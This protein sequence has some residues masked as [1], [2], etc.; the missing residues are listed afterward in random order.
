MPSCLDTKSSSSHIN[1]LGKR[2]PCS[3]KL[4]MWCQYWQQLA[5]TSWQCSSPKLHANW[6]LNS[7]AQGHKDLLLELDLFEVC[8]ATIYE[9]HSSENSNCLIHSQIHQTPDLHTDCELFLF[10]SYLFYLRPYFAP[11]RT[12]MQT[13]TCDLIPNLNT[14]SRHWKQRRESMRF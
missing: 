5:V 9:C 6:Q 13:Q 12:V 8:Y 11:V 10:H 4:S 7:K 14:S 3:F 1:K 2:L